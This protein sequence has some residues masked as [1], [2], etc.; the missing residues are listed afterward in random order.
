MFVV[1]LDMQQLIIECWKLSVQ[2]NKVQRFIMSNSL[3]QCLN[4]R[5]F[6][7]LKQYGVDVQTSLHAKDKQVHAS[8][9]KI[10]F[11]IVLTS[12][13]FTILNENMV[14][15]IENWESIIANQAVNIDN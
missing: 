2:S 14:E 9:S 6:F 12:N 15:K 13:A 11:S 3:I 1:V 4:R 7:Y 10:D 8:S 5:K